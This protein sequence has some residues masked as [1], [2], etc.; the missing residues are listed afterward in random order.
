M[1]N[2]KVFNFALGVLVRKAV[3]EEDLE[4]LKSLIN[5]V[6]EHIVLESIKEGFFYE[7]AQDDDEISKEYY[8]KLK[9]LNLLKITPRNVLSAEILNYIGKIVIIKTKAPFDLLGITTSLKGEVIRARYNEEQQD[10][11]VWVKEEV[12]EEVQKVRSV[13][14]AS[15]KR[16]RGGAKGLFSGTVT[17]LGSNI[18][19]IEIVE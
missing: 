12:K 13:R 15:G 1:A 8:C 14:R 2:F 5:P 19:S 18:E 3:D 4:N 6:R 11:I 10:F 9:K 17:I 7:C 16:T